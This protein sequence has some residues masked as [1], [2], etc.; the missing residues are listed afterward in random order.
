MDGLSGIES[1]EIEFF[2]FFANSSRIQS[3]KSLCLSL[4]LLSSSFGIEVQTE[5]IKINTV[6]KGSW[7]CSN[8]LQNTSRIGPHWRR[9][10]SKHQFSTIHTRWKILKGCNGDSLKILFLGSCQNNNSWICTPPRF[11]CLSKSLPCNG[12]Q[13]ILY[14]N[15]F[16]SNEILDEEPSYWSFNFIVSVSSGFK[17]HDLIGVET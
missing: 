5:I 8:L 11:P 17:Q 13:P 14:F 3:N 6:R 2:S 12:L 9:I 15:Y 1:L 10:C 16:F 7:I 4:E